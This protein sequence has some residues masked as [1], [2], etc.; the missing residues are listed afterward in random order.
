MVINQFYKLFNV[1]KKNSV[2][3]RTL[4]AVN[5]GQR[6]YLNCTVFVIRSCL[7][8]QSQQLCIHYIRCICVWAVC[9]CACLHARE[10]MHV[11]THCMLANEYVCVCVWEMQGFGGGW[12]SIIWRSAS[13]PCCCGNT[14]ILSMS[15][16]CVALATLLNESRSVTV[17]SRHS[18]E[19]LV[20]MAMP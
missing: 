10:I 15:K 2:F 12:K 17:E 19:S 13:H 14:E 8:V 20:A 11:H 5:V 18:E 3:N 6:Y 7:C 1:V 9:V 16:G 4:A